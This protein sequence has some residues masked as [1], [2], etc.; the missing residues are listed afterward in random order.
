MVNIDRSGKTKEGLMAKN[1]TQKFV[2]NGQKYLALYEGDKL[3]RLLNTTKEEEVPSY[4][5][6]FRRLA[7]GNRGNKFKA[8]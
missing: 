1:S 2:R 4:T 5:Q 7:D 3:V 6:T 8:I